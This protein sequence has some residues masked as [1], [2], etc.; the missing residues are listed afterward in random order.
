MVAIALCLLAIAAGTY[1][2]III[3]RD[4]LGKAYSVLAWGIIIASLMGIGF[5]GYKAVMHRG[6]KQQCEQGAC[7]KENKGNCNGN[8]KP[9]CPHGGGMMEGN[10]ACP[11]M[12]QGM[13]CPMSC[14]VVGDS[15]VMD[16]AACEKMMGKEGCAKM[17][18]ERGRCIMSLDEC[19]KMSGGAC[20]KA[21][22]PG[23]GKACCKGE[24]EKKM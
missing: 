4:F 6:C 11:H 17:V 1:L 18:A 20:T 10:G 15:C 3:K 14:Q 16:Q 21:C 13:A 8:A 23:E 9:G 22:T 7:D 5:T 2:L 24:G 19:S 12:Q